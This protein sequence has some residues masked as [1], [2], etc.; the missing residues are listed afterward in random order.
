M[1]II[2]SQKTLI[3]NQQLIQQQ[4]LKS[5]SNSSLISYFFQWLV[6]SR[7]QGNP[8]EERLQGS[9]RFHLGD[10][11]ERLAIQSQ[12]FIPSVI[13]SSFHLSAFQASL[14]RRSHNQFCS[15]LRFD[16]TSSVLFFI[17]S[18]KANVPSI[19]VR[20]SVLRF[21][22]SKCVRVSIPSGKSSSLERTHFD[23][24]KNLH[25]LAQKTQFQDRRLSLLDDCI[26]QFGFEAFISYVCFLSFEF[27]RLGDL[28]FEVFLFRR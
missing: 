11:C 6:P 20:S 23:R 5:I 9:M 14:N 27:S 22:S 16:S 28:E 12:G 1:C 7:R 24:S 8:P 3:P 19:I 13:C 26:Y 4:S 25:K 2:K 10:Y 18:W 15:V 21:D 17:P